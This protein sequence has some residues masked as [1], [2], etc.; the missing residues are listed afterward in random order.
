MADNPERL[1]CI[2]AIICDDVFRDEMTKKLVIVGT[3]N[4]L[5]T[6]SFPAVHPRMCLL[7]SLTN[8]KGEYQLSVSVQHEA[9]G[10]EVVRVGGPF[11]M[12]TPLAVADVD[13]RFGNLHL[14]AAGKYW[15]VIESDG[16]PINQRPFFVQHAEPARLEGDARHDAQ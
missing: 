12:P 15:V 1:T 4:V 11:H 2:S 9:S 3:F 5:T 8:G 6:G 14:P 16:V 7:F 10:I 13:V